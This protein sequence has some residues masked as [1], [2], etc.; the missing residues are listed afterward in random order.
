MHIR[1]RFLLRTA[2]LVCA[3]AT[4]KLGSNASAQVS[5]LTLSR[6]ELTLSRGEL[7]FFHGS[8]AFAPAGLVMFP[9][10]EFRF[11][12]GSFEFSTTAFEVSKS[13]V[14]FPIGP[15]R[16]ETSGTIEVVLPADLLFG[17]RKDDISPTAGPE[18]HEVAEMIRENGALCPV[19]I[20][21]FTDLPGPDGDGRA[22]PEKSWLERI[23]DFV[24]DTL[25]TDAS[26]RRLSEQVA[27]SVKIWL[28]THEG[29]APATLKPVGLGSRDP[30]AP[31][32][33]P[34]GSDDP[35]GRKSN[36]RV[37]FIIPKFPGRNGDCV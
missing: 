36:R 35:D 11:A 19:I 5:P 4:P 6:G 1:A 22:V 24:G 21:G 34:D 27:R 31:N 13:E 3:L 23:S 26:N 14:V 2:I 15:E 9:R 32:R 29:L 37:K 17:L 12:E 10:G 18:L 7:T 30:V 8:L 16:H 25:G 28:E 33:R 20:E